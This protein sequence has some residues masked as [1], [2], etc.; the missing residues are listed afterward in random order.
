MSIN[1]QGIYAVAGH[2]KERYLHPLQFPSNKPAKTGAEA[3]AGK[4][5][6]QAPKAG[7]DEHFDHVMARS[8]DLLAR[9]DPHRGRMDALRA[10]AHRVHEDHA[11]DS[12]G[13]HAEHS[14][15]ATDLLHTFNSRMGEIQAQT[16][17]ST[18]GGWA[19]YNDTFG[20]KP[21]APAPAA[22]APA[23]PKP[24]RVVQPGLFGPSQVAPVRSPQQ[25]GLAASA[26]GPKKGSAPKPP[27]RRPRVT[28]PGLFPKSAVKK[29]RGFPPHR[30]IG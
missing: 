18:S 14:S 3:S 4:N 16:K 24:Q 17:P 10:E 26:E 9:T 30:E 19:A 6:R 5:A 27:Q 22:P 28:Q 12:Y 11:S 23:A 21:S 8:G 7:T 15:A 29:S 2:F 1:V 25:F 13:W 20:P